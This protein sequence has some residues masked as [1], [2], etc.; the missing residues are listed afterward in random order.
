MHAGHETYY[1]S[2]MTTNEVLL[3]KGYD[4]RTDLP[5][6]VPHAGFRLP[7]AS[8]DAPPRESIELRAFAFWD[9]TT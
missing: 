9:W 8:D 3:F 4:T 6:F 7:D 5:R 1:V 2:A